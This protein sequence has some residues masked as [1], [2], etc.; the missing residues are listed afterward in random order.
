MFDITITPYFRPRHTGG[1]WTGRFETVPSLRVLTRTVAKGGETLTKG[2]ADGTLPSTEE[3]VFLRDAVHPK[4][5]L[6]LG[7]PNVKIPTP[8][9]KGRLKIHTII[10]D[11]KVLGD[12]AI[13]E[14]P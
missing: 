2:M 13:K 3:N 11:E 6:I 7:A 8:D 5:Q 12:I 4:C 1:V 10:R 14:T 9:P